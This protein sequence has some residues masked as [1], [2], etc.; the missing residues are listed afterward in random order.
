MDT[1]AS[2]SILPLPTLD[3]LGIL[4]ERIIQEPLQVVGIGVLQQCTLG[5]V[6]LD[7]TVRPIRARTLVHVMDGDTSYHII[8]GLP[9]L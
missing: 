4:R 8:L 5:Y 2:T 1:G 3:A 7:L 6:S 9:W